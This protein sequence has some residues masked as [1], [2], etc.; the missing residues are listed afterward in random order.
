MKEDTEVVSTAAMVI[1][2]Q[3]NVQ[4]Y[5]LKMQVRLLKCEP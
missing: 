5:A 3:L 2:N 4:Q 1:L